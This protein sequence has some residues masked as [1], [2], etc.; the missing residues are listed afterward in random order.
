MKDG[1]ASAVQGS[2]GCTYEGASSPLSRNI[3]VSTIRHVPVGGR[4]ELADTRTPAHGP[5]SSSLSPGTAPEDSK[6]L[7]EAKGRAAARPKVTGA[8]CFP[9]ADKRGLEAPRPCDLATL[10]SPAAPPSPAGGTGPLLRSSGKEDLPHRLQRSRV[11]LPPLLLPAQGLHPH[12]MEPSS[13]LKPPLPLDTGFSPHALPSAG[14]PSPLALLPPLLPARFSS[15]EP[16][17]PLPTWVRSPLPTLQWHPH[18]WVFP[19]CEL[20][21]LLLSPAHILNSVRAGATAPYVR[22]V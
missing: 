13:G 16:Y 20:L 17:L 22:R 19:S 12:R 5:H 14:H 15:G 1:N 9:A 6:I 11:S 18:P 7:C 4:R 8:A 21:G 3:F 2:G 10:G